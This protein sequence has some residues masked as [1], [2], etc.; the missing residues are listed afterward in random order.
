ME[1][2]RVKVLLKILDL[3]RS[4]R[5][6][7]RGDVSSALSM[8]STSVSELVNELIKLNLLVET[9]L[10]PTHRG[11]PAGVLTF[12][13]QRLGAILLTV[14]DRSI[15]AEAVDMDFNILASASITPPVDAENVVLVAGLNRLIYD[16]E[17][18]FAH[19]IKICGIAAA[20]IGLLDVPRGLWC[21]SSRWP[22]MNNLNVIESLSAHP[23]PVS[24]IRNLDA[25]LSGLFQRGVARRAE[26]VLLL[27][28]GHGIGAS[29]ASAGRVINNER[30]RFCEIGHWQLS[31]SEGRACTCGNQDCLETVAALWAIEGDLRRAFPDLPSGAEALGLALAQVDIIGNPVLSEA[32]KQMLR[33]T[34]NLCRLLF[35]DRIVLSGPVVQNPG[36]FHQFVNGI[37]EGRLLSTVDMIRVTS[38]EVTRSFQV[39]GALQPVFDRAIEKMLRKSS[40]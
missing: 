27:H 40:A 2:N 39:I 7:T 10:K 35:P 18:S 3:V 19:H 6:H 25:E 17:Q 11:R 32:I 4:G 14:V 20:L 30:G 9:T 31:N 37:Q 16:I 1:F 28:W 13:S 22:K 26:N 33:A 8:R 38:I 5:A 36:V 23:W 12:N 29:Y 15:I 24:L 21:V 34:G